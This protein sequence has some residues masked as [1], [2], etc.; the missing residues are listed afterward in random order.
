MEYIEGT[1]V[2]F[3]TAKSTPADKIKG[4]R[5]GADGFDMVF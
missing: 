3:V 4:F 1:P 2:I 5:L